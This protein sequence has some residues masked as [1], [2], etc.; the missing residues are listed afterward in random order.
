MYSKDI[1]P[2]CIYC[3]HSKSEHNNSNFLCKYKGV[4]SFDFSCRKY[5]YDATKRIPPKKHALKIEINQ[6]ICEI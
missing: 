4:V 6:N 3:V 5:C 2:M 1:T